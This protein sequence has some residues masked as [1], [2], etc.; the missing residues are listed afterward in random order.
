MIP[1]ETWVTYFKR[2]FSETLLYPCAVLDRIPA[3]EDG[4]WYRHG[5]WGCR[6]GLSKPWGWWG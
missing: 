6:L 3:Y 5:A 4:R 1:E 2:H